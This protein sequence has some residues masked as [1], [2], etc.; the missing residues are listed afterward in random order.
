MT[1]DPRE[2]TIRAAPMPSDCNS[3]GDI[4]GGWVLSQMDIAGGIAASRRA[5]GRVVTRAI[6]AMTF[7]QPIRAGDIVSIYAEVVRIGRSSV[8]VRMETIVRRRLGQDQIKVT[9]GDFVYVAIDDQG[10][11]RTLDDPGE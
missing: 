3:N 7:D 1:D 2:P 4:F 8:T 9:G 11:P 5:G 10:R 6:E